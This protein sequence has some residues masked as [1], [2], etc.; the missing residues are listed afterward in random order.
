VKLAA[1]AREVAL[2]WLQGVDAT[3]DWSAALA[4]TVGAPFAAL[5]LAAAPQ[6]D[7]EMA[8]VPGLL[9]RPDADIVGLAER[10]QQRQPAE[11]LRWIE[12]WVTERIRKGLLA[13]APGHSPATPG[14]P[15]GL[16]TR[17]IQGLF[18]VLDEARSA[19]NALK[20]PANVA[21]LFERLFV[22]LARELEILR[23]SRARP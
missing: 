4:L 2:A 8:E 17:H 15:A 21:M 1:P 20:G 13:P 11:R 12:N 18:R 19:Q 22:L 14:L 23:T 10:C 9:G 3:V 7:K 5:A 6:L 16:R